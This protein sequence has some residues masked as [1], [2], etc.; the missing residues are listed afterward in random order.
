MLPRQT[1]VVTGPVP[2]AA[3]NT[4]NRPRTS[5][6][7]SLPTSR[8]TPPRV[9]RPAPP[10]ALVLAVRLALARPALRAAMSP[11]PLTAGPLLPAL[12]AATRLAPTA[13][14]PPLRPTAVPT[15]PAPTTP[16]SP[17]APTMPA[18]P[19]LLLTT[20][21]PAPPPTPTAPVVT[22]RAPVT[23]PRTRRPS[24]RRPSAS[25]LSSPVLPSTPTSKLLPWKRGVWT[26]FSVLWE[27]RLQVTSSLP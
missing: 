27:G 12:R 9:T 15:L 25:V 19:L 20:R 23:S 24:S 16:R 1:S 21:S 2:D 22:T 11:L 18:S 26:Q 5:L 3:A 7:A 14:T 4:P 8:L 17:P 10:T 13:L 6:R